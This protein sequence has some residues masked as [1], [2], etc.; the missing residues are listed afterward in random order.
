MRKHYYYDNAVKAIKFIH[1]NR[2]WTL[3]DL[4]E[5]MGIAKR[6]AFN[7]RDTLSR[8]YPVREVRTIPNDHPNGGGV[9]PMLYTIF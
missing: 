8:H 3:R 4:E 6:T 2:Y 7:I 9:R 5:H 1:D